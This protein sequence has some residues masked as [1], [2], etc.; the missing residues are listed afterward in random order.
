VPYVS[1]QRRRVSG[2][3]RGH[4]GHD[5]AE[6]REVLQRRHLILDRPACLEIIRFQRSLVQLDCRAETVRRP[7]VEGRIG[8][9][10]L[11]VEAGR[12]IVLPRQQLVLA[13]LRRDVGLGPRALRPRAQRSD[14]AAVHEDLLPLALGRHVLEGVI[15]PC[16]GRLIRNPV[17]VLVAVPGDH[18]QRREAG[19]RAAAR[20]AVGQVELLVRVDV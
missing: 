5:Q 1:Y 16:Q 6:A 15:G 3:A 9:Q 2:L 18:G 11:V 19:V 13:A 7:G 12:W 20:V 10:D 4:S 17:L 8:I 14:H